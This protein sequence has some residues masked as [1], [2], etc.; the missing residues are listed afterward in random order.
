METIVLKN[1]TVKEL[2]AELK[3]PKLKDRIQLFYCFYEQPLK[4]PFSYFQI[5]WGEEVLKLDDFRDCLVAQPKL[6]LFFFHHPEANLFTAYLTQLGVP[7]GIVVTE[8]ERFAVNSFF[9]KMADGLTVAKAYEVTI[10]ASG[11]SRPKESFEN[12]G[13]QIEATTG[14]LAFS[15][16]QGVSFYQAIGQQQK[17][18]D[19]PKFQKPNS[20]VEVSKE[21]HLVFAELIIADGKSDQ[22]TKELVYR[23]EQYFQ[24]N[25]YVQVS[26]LVSTS[27]EDLLEKLRGIKKVSILHII[28]RS[29][30][31]LFNGNDQRIE[32]QLY[33][34][35]NN[36]HNFRL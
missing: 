9:K 21:I 35:L 11:F 26:L 2:K 16:H 22:T 15:N 34:V 10:E 24:D 30:I 36:N 18:E 1:P 4:H 31:H 12:F 19:W 14:G 17:L 13:L 3:T 8:P 6:H 28:Y 23:V 25:P 20:N 7:G 32:D 29:P 33:Q 27:A 5:S